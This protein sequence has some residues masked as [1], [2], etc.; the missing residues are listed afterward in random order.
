L[1]IFVIRFS[2]VMIKQTI[3]TCVLCLGA[4]MA[5]AQVPVSP[6]GKP[7]GPVNA[8]DTTRKR[9]VIV[10]PGG[11]AVAP[12]MAVPPGTVIV[13]DSVSKRPMAIVPVTEPAKKVKKSCCKKHDGTT[14]CDETKGTSAKPK[15]APAKKD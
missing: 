14:P 12:E 3:L 7:G 13:I 6:V 9:P 10:A 15:T 4:Y 1:I 5:N 2:I 8:S 11:A